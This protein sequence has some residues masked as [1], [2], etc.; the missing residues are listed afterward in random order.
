NTKRDACKKAVTL[1]TRE[2]WVEIVL[3]NFALKPCSI[4]LAIRDFVSAIVQKKP[5]TASCS[6]SLAA[7]T[8]WFLP[9][10]LVWYSI[11]S[12]LASWPAGKFRALSCFGLRVPDR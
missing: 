5:C 6:Y 9:A 8:Y 10:S 1:G 3:K 11:F 7:K 12:G 2:S 4:C